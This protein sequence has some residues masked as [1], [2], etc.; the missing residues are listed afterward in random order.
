MSRIIQVAKPQKSVFT[1][2]IAGVFI[3]IVAIL[4]VISVVSAV[5]FS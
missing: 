2:I 3:A 5:I 1:K 4:F